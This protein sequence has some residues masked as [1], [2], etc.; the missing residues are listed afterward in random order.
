MDYAKKD[1]DISC[2]AELTPYLFEVHVQNQQISS[3]FNSHLS[4]TSPSGLR[5]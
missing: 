1:S 2:M 3:G 4:L 5:K